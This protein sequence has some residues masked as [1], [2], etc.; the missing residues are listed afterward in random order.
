M[1]NRELLLCVVAWMIP[2]AGHLMQS[3]QLKGFVFFVVLTFMFSLGLWLEGSLFPFDLSQPL[4]FL[5]ALAELGMGAPYFVTKVLGSG[6]G[7][8]LAGSHEY[9]NAFVIV[10]GLLNML[11]VLDTY[12]LATGQ[13]Q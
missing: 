3:R 6:E 1:K 7:Q 12:D 4:V 5:S 8:L 2:G 9:G 13:K 10:A 11:V